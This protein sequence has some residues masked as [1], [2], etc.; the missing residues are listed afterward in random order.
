MGFLRFS[1]VVKLRHCDWNHKLFYLCLSKG[2]RQKRNLGVYYKTRR[3][4]MPH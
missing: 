2:V 4:Y 3:S 1:E